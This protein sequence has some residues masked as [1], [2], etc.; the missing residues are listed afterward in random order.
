MEYLSSNKIAIIDLSNGEIIEEELDENLVREKIGGA[1]ITTFLYHKYEKEAPIVL[2]SGLLTG[3]LVPGSALAVMTAKSPRTGTV[4]HAPL[5]LLAGMELKFSGFD[6]LVIK[7]TSIKPVYLWLHDGIAD[8]QGAEGLWGKEVWEATETVR[9][10]V[11]DDLVQV[12]TIGPAGE[13]GSDL[14]QVGINFWASG[15]AWGFGK[16]FGQK[17][18]KLIA[19]RGMGLLEIADPEGFIGQCQEL[20]TLIKGGAWAAQKGMGDVLTALGETDMDSWLSP[21]IHRH[22]SCFNTPFATN[23][24]IYLDEDPK[25]LK[26]TEK[27]DPGMLLT[28]YRA[29]SGF[30]KLGLS[31]LECGRI[32][33]SCAQKGLDPGGVSLL[34]QKSGLK[35]EAGIL[36][37][38]S[39]AQGPL[40]SSD[41]GPFSPWIPGRPI[42]ADFG[43]PGDGSQDAVWW[44]R[45]Q[46]LAHVFGIHP[47]FALMAP[48]LS[49]EKLL[50]LANLGTDLGLTAE[51]LEQVISDLNK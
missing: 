41:S 13:S 18:L 16:L 5:T 21:V 42:F 25:L 2:G 43:L 15:D 7:G 32:L 24:F 8:I 26:E 30:K 48:E 19:V 37:F 23:T 20:L 10:T 50:K 47:V 38:L 46:A 49:E 44:R 14:A 34:C 40:E 51:T 27:P 39:Q 3:T 6:Y 1:G 9:K 11:G 12:L 45:R 31:V 28:D 17:K 29:L 33:K 35:D 22:K 4:C 36:Q